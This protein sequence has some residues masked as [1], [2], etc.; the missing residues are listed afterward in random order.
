MN[1]LT[2]SVLGSYPHLPTFLQQAGFSCK[3][4][5]MTWIDGWE[6]LSKIALHR[7]G[8]D[9]SLI[10]TSWL[11]SLVSAYAVRSFSQQEID[12]LGGSAVFVPA[13]WQTT[14]PHSIPRARVW[15]IPWVS[16]VRLIFYWRDMLEQAGIDEKTAFQTPERMEETMERLQAS[17]VK[18]PWGVW[19]DVAYIT[20]HN[21][22]T[23]IW[24]A[25]GDFLSA[26]GK[27]ILFDQPEALN[28]LMDWTTT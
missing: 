20:L 4:Q 3:V 9:V 21:A 2:F 5:E 6:E 12:A 27:R 15:A 7:S 24:Q 28:G 18:A 26:D 25:G 23:W 16:D 14:S 8:P 1:D 19:A 13:L 11:D 17:D 22:S 10:G